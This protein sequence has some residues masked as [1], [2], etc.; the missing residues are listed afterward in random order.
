MLATAIGLGGPVALRYPRGN[1]LGVALDQIIT[2][3]PVGCAELL[4]KGTDA[5]VL[6][7]G[8]LVHPALEAALQLERSGGPSLTVINAR[9][10]KPLDQALIML[11]AR[12][13][14]CLITLEENVLQGGFGSAV[15]ELLEEQQLTGVRVLRLGYPDSPIPQ[16]E[17][18]D[19]RA[20]LGLDAKGIAA[21]IRDFLGKN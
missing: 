18:Q 15:L 19:L 1:G 20:M 14:G 3:L 13:H 7:L 17:Q 8:S 12:S 16:G 21:S 5:V 10:V 2:P 11:M 4:R 6:A 9:F